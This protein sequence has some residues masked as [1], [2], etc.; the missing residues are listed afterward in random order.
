MNSRSMMMMMMAKRTDPII[1]LSGTCERTLAS[2]SEKKDQQ[3]KEDDDESER[4]QD[5]FTIQRNDGGDYNPKSRQGSLC[6]KAYDDKPKYYQE[7]MLKYSNKQCIL[8]LNIRQLC[9]DFH[10]DPRRIN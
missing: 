2:E 8:L 4:T 7:V 1:I 9:M 10:T 3:E 6:S 5:D